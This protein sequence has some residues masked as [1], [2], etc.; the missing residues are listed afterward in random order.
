MTERADPI[1]S[2]ALQAILPTTT[3]YGNPDILDSQLL[4]TKPHSSVPLYSL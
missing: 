2:S 4:P 1:L 3:L